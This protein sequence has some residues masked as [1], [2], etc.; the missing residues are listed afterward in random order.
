MC[1]FVGIVD[2][3]NCSRDVVLSLQALQHR[4]QDS[5]GLGTIDHGQFPLVKR[6]GLVHQGFGTTEIEQT[7]GKICIGHVR[8][9]TVGAG[10]LRDAQPFF[11]RQ[12]GVL[13]AHNGNLTNLRE[14][15][16]ELAENSVHLMS[17]CDVEPVLCI[18]SQELM[19]RRR[20]DHRLEDAVEAMKTTM[21]HIQGA[22]S[23]VVALVLDGQETLLALRDP[24][25][26]RPAVWGQLPD[27]KGWMVASESVAMDAL[28]VKRCGD[29]APGELMVF[30]TGSKPIRHQLK[31][32]PPS[33]CIFEYIYFARPDSHMNGASVYSKRLAMG[34]A[35]A[36]AWRAKGLEADV[37]I[38]IPDTSRPAAAAVAERL[39]LPN[40]EGF[41]KNRYTGRTFIMAKANQRA[42]ALKLKLNP[43]RS[44]FAGRRVLVVDDSIVRGTT[45]KH[46]IEIIRAQGPTQVHLAI[47]SPPVLHPCYYGIDISTKEELVAPRFLPEGI[48][49][50]EPEALKQ[51]ELSF[52]A[53]L[54]L[55]SLT[56]L[57]L[58]GLRAA[59]DGPACAACFDGRYPTPL[60]EKQRSW[61]AED[62]RKSDQRT[63]GI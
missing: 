11:F 25:G 46:T 59:F 29:V 43:I 4:G 52:A 61:I 60:D 58:D 49:E 36:D 38:P 21:E 50:T 41:I 57:P 53:R 1:G 56:Y 62:R 37:V 24:Q 45:L 39:R 42:N 5:A 31:T 44:E 13:M 2:G 55:D 7:P 32:A 12:P 16:D 15:H 48:K 14:M 9:P 54:G 17:S 63:L 22:Y 20:R 26:I 23:L 34:R 35:L 8:Y 3:K 47:Y 6:L 10:V 33:P 40:R 28:S 18:F 51:I 19:K 30:R 27:K